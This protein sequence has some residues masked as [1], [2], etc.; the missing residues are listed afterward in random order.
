MGVRFERHALQNLGIQFEGGLLNLAK[1]IIL[2][3]SEAPPQEVAKNWGRRRVIFT[4]KLGKCWR[5]L[6]HAST[7]AFACKVLV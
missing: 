3:R 4:I 5:S 1:E 7:A 2:K 6:G